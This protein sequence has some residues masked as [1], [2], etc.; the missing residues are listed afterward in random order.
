[1]IQNINFEKFTYVIVFT[2]LV[3]LPSCTSNNK[4]PRDLRQDIARMKLLLSNERIDLFVE[5]YSNEYIEYKSIKSNGKSDIML[6]RLSK[7]I[8]VDEL[9]AMLEAAPSSSKVAYSEGDIGISYRVT[10][11]RKQFEYDTLEFIRIKNE[12]SWRINLPGR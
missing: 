10:L 1:M 12:S 6:S 8:D 7:S 2:V 3:A 9:L 4:L 5:K 11:D